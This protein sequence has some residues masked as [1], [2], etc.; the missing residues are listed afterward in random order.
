MI[1]KSDEVTLTQFYNRLPPKLEAKRVEGLLPQQRE[2]VESAYLPLPEG[3]YKIRDDLSYGELS[4]LT[5]IEAI[6]DDGEE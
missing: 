2:L 3:G 5:R 1:Q 6:T 4:R